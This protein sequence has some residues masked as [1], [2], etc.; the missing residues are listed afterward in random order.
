MPFKIFGISRAIPS[1]MTN[2]GTI[3]FSGAFG[4]L[5]IGFTHVGRMMLN[6]EFPT[7]AAQKARYTKAEMTLIRTLC[8]K[9]R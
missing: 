1:G 3:G 7:L 9:A 4:N 8:A 2:I 5:S 6:K